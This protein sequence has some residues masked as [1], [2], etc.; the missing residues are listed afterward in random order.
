MKGNICRIEDVRKHVFVAVIVLFIDV[1]KESKISRLIK[2][3]GT[4]YSRLLKDA[5]GENSLS[6]VPVFEWYKQ[7]PERRESTEEDQRPGS[8]Y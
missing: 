8:S 4:K 1:R 5:Y 7:F 3:T 6:R 2:K